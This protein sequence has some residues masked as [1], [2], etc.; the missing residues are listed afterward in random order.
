MKV[1]AATHL[2]KRFNTITYEFPFSYFSSHSK[3][4]SVLHDIRRSTASHTPETMWRLHRYLMA[5][6]SPQ[7][8][9]QRHTRRHLR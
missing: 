5:E 6:K 3:K 7:R 2:Q 4:A 1:S 8:K 9:A